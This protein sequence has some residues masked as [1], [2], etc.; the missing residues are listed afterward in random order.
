VK[1][2]Q[3]ISNPI[4]RFLFFFVTASDDTN[5]SNKIFGN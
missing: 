1:M 3:Q 5:D 4:I 2:I